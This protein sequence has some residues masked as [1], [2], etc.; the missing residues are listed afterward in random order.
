MEPVSTITGVWSIAK[1]A[2][3]ISK[4][5]Y[6][7][8]RSLKDR[9]EK[10]RVDEILDS[11]RELKQAASQL[12]DENRGLRE[13]LRFKSNDYEFRTPFYYEKSHPEQPLCPKC[14]SKGT[15]APMGEPGQDCSST[16]RRCL[17]CGG[18]IQVSQGM[19]RAQIRPV[20]RRYT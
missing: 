8:G 16:Y 11:V 6:D 10:Q 5:L 9:E 20:V 14:F 3:E 18:C 1:T 17:V 7:L 2:G 12:E 15:P 4:K 13:R 19:G